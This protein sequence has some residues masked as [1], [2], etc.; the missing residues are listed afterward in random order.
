MRG[1]EEKRRKRILLAMVIFALGIGAIA[2]KAFKGYDIDIPKDAKEVKILYQFKESVVETE[3]A[4]AMT[5]FFNE[6]EMKETMEKDELSDEE[7]QG[8]FKIFFMKDGHSKEILYL[9]TNHMVYDPSERV[10]FMLD[11]EQFNVIFELV[12]KYKGN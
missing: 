10:A 1:S 3:D 6:L 7:Y 8:S 2:I 4:K 11:D 9:L 12:E 5:D